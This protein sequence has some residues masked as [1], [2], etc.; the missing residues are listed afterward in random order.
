MKR[1]L[2]AAIFLIAIAAVAQ[3]RGGGRFEPTSEDIP[4]QDAE[5]N[6]IRMEYT[7]NTGRGFGFVSRNGRA[8]GWWAQDWPDADNHFTVGI[9]RLTRINAGDP[10]H[11]SFTDPQLFDYPWVYLTLTGYWDLSKEEITQLGEY[12]KRGG[13]LMTDDFWGPNPRE[14][15]NFEETMNEALPNH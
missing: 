11:V 6:F 15:Q 4:H 1:F 5:F 13:F 3:R 10:R 12:L 7:D 14:W 2:L 8:R 9:Q